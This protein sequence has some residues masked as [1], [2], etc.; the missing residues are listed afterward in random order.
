MT[1][2]TRGR[3]EARKARDEF[4]AVALPDAADALR[5]ARRRRRQRRLAAIALTL[6]VAILV[7][8]VVLTRPHARNGGITAGPSFNAPLLL[9]I[10]APRTTMVTGTTMTVN[11]AIDN[12]TGSVLKLTDAH[13]CQPA[14]AVA[15][16]NDI[17]PANAAFALPCIASPLVIPIGPSRFPFTIRAS[18]PLCSETGRTQSTVPVCRNGFDPPP[19][20]PGDYQLSF[21]DNGSHLP[22][23]ALV[24]VHVTANP[25]E[26][27]TR[28]AVVAGSSDGNAPCAPSQ[29][30]T[31]GADPAHPQRAP[32]LSTASF[33]RGLGWAI[34]GASQ[35][36]DG[37]LLN[38]RTT[39]HG[40]TWTVTET[41]LTFAPTRPGEQVTVTLS[42]ARGAQIHIRSPLPRIDTIYATLD[43]GRTW[44]VAVPTAVPS[45]GAGATIPSRAAPFTLD[46]AAASASFIPAGFMPVKTP[47]GKAIPGHVSG[48]VPG[49]TND[50]QQFWNATTNQGFVISVERGQPVSLILTAGP[51]PYLASARR[52]GDRDTY[53]RTDPL[54]SP[55]REFTWIVGPTTTGFVGGFKMPDDDLL[56]IADGISITP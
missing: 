24:T 26:N 11:L 42:T 55:E 40:T 22:P 39:N 13:G 51:V 17:V 52:V 50:G 54:A 28:A 43:G 31:Y 12:H 30:G 44:H 3:T 4:Q 47:V 34:C 38:L 23:P 10:E 2:D 45:T 36:G 1:L 20:P 46:D 49:W 16:G 32:L 56:R 6:V 9:R 48:P 53:V 35:T 7:A 19:L 8:G 33:P 25:A 14:F 15:L 29:P 21:A 18:Y 41:G 37:V 5:S 27:G